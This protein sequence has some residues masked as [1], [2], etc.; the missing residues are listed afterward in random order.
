[1]SNNSIN[2]MKKKNLFYYL[3]FGITLLNAV[4]T[5]TAD[6]TNGTTNTM[7]L[8]Q[9]SLGNSTLSDL[10]SLST[11]SNVFN[12]IAVNFTPNETGTYVMGQYT[13]DTDTIMMLYSGNFDPSNPSVGGIIGNDDTLA[14]DHAVYGFTSFCGTEDYCP[15][16]TSDLISGHQYTLVVS[17]YWHDDS[18]SLPVSFYADRVGL[19]SSYTNPALAP[20]SISFDYPTIQ[21]NHLFFAKRSLLMNQLDDDCE[22]SDTNHIC[23]KVGGQFFSF[24]KESEKINKTIASLI[25]S[26]QFNSNI[27]IG[28]FI[29][30]SLYTNYNNSVL[31]IE[32]NPIIG[33]FVSR[34]DSQPNKLVETKISYGWLKNDIEITRSISTNTEAGAGS[35]FLKTTGF[36]LYR[37]YSFFNQSIN[38]SIR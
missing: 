5:Y 6:Q 36:Q 12:Y 31:N 25:G 20:A 26:Y 4:T 23:L 3:V 1:V 16:I 9:G 34:K 17:T 18:L 38:Q 8:S 22:T 11:G 28:G 35:T 10:S 7:S 32:S 37:K 2:N 19:F 21:L 13:A 33:L 15:Q 29:D 24:D 27:R 14:D 30:K